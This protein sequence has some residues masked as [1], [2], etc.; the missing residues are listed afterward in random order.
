MAKPAASPGSLIEE[1][2]RVIWRVIGHFRLR[3]HDAEDAYQA[4]CEKVI[5]YGGT[6]R[7]A[8]RAAGWV[9]VVARNE[10]QQLL[11]RNSRHVPFGDIEQFFDG[12]EP[13]SAADEPSLAAD[14][15][16]EVR[17]A[18]ATLPDRAQRLLWLLAGGA[19]HA[20]IV[21]ATGMP[22]GSIGPTWGRSMAKLRRA[23]AAPRKE[24]RDAG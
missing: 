3:H 20:E 6:I 7:D 15:A 13:G 9:G 14:S 12:P 1:H 17:E 23:L 16:R 4:T 21:S 2:A 8:A 10:C 24:A 19:T 11:N 18:V 5:R 22:A